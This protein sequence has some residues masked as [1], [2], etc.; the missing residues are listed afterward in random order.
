MLVHCTYIIIE[1]M[2]KNKCCKPGRQ[3]QVEGHSDKG[4]L[5]FTINQV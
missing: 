2:F 4:E 1:E 5:S 3:G